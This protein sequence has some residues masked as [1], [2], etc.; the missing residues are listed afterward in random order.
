MLINRFIWKYKFSQVKA[1]VMR[2][3]HQK[4]DL[5]GPS[6]TKHCQASQLTGG[7]SSLIKKPVGHQSSYHATFCFIPYSRR[8]HVL[9]TVLITPTAALSLHD[10]LHG[11][12]FVAFPI[13][14][15]VLSNIFVNQSPIDPVMHGTLLQLS[16]AE[17][18]LL[19]REKI[20]IEKITCKIL[21][22]NLDKLRKIPF[23]QSNPL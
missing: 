2:E 20:K 14:V 6:I 21:A 4:G 17:W 8:T 1:E 13:L 23:L 19:D 3:N 5:A 12:S 10:I 16:V 22:R 9:C 18:T 11:H 15:S 7:L